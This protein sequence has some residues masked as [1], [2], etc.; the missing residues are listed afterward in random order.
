MKLSL[1]S[2]KS[3]I[4]FYVVLFLCCMHVDDTKW[5]GWMTKLLNCLDCFALRAKDRCD[6]KLLSFVLACLGNIYILFLESKKLVNLF[7]LKNYH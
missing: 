3:C 5:F 1:Y 2:M 6:I 7:C 4:P